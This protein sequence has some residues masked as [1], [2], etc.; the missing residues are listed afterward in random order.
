M[1]YEIYEASTFHEALIIFGVIDKDF[2]MCFSRLI[3]N[4][5]LALL[6]LLRRQV[7]IHSRPRI[8]RLSELNV[9]SPT[10]SSAMTT[11]L[12][13]SRI[14]TLTRSVLVMSRAL[15]TFIQVMH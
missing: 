1:E 11:T 4:D 12:S 8:Q 7:L 3:Q 14:R 10:L 13:S 2:I 6:D 15:V 5:E 9:P